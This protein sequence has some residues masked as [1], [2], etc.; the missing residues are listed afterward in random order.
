[1]DKTTQRTL[2]QAGAVRINSV[3]PLSPAARLVLEADGYGVFCKQYGDHYVSA[4]VIGGEA[5]VTVMQ[6]SKAHAASE[7]LKATAEAHLLCFSKEAV[8]AEKDAQESYRGTQFGVFVFDSLTQ[9][10]VD[11]PLKDDRASSLK[12][13]RGSHSCSMA[14]SRQCRGV[15]RNAWRASQG[16]SSLA[17]SYQ[18]TTGLVT[19]SGLITHFVL[20]A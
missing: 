10:L 7:K 19:R 15:F 16:S 18:R 11:M 6:E 17:R 8:V 12:I 14:S 9:H 2:H 20:T 13:Q 4:V 3:P 5:A 1:M